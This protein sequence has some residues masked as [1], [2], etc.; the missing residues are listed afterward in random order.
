MA[1]SIK[2]RRAYSPFFVS[3]IIAVFLIYIDRIGIKASPNFA[4]RKG[5]VHHTLAHASSGPDFVRPLL[6]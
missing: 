5:F 2:A 3:F 6:K 1:K 4:T